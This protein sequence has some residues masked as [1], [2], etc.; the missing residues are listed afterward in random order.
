[1]K[2]YYITL[3]D[4]FGNALPGSSV[5]VI[6]DAS[7]QQSIYKDAGGTR[8]TNEAGTVINTA[9]ADDQGYVEFYWEPAAGHSLQIFSPTGLLKRIIENFAEIAVLETAL[10]SSTG[11]GMI[12]TANGDTVQEHIAIFGAATPHYH[13][14]I[15][16]NFA[17]DQTTAVQ[18]W[19]NHCD[20]NGIPPQTPRQI[21]AK[22]SATITYDPSGLVGN[23]VMPVIDMRNLT[24][25]SSATPGFVLGS[26]S[27]AIDGA[28]IYLPNVHRATVEWSGGLT[29]PCAA[30]VIRNVRFS[31]VWLPDVRYYT[32]GVQYIS[33]G[34]AIVYNEFYGGVL[35]DNRIGEQLLTIGASSYI[36]ENAWFGGAVGYSTVTGAQTAAFSAGTM[37]KI[38]ASGYTGN[39]NNVWYK[40]SYEVT[41]ATQHPNVTEG[42]PIWLEGANYNKW[43]DCRLEGWRGPAMHVEG[44]V[45][46][47]ANSTIGL[48]NEFNVGLVGTV[49]G[50]GA[51]LA[52]R[53]IKGA[54]ANH[55]TRRNQANAIAWDSGPLRAK[56]WSGGTAD[57]VAISAPFFWREG[58]SVTNRRR[59]TFSNRVATNVHGLQFNN[60]GVFVM[61]DT[62]RVKD[63]TFYAA[64]L[65]GWPGDWFFQP[66]DANFVKIADTITD[67]NGTERS[68]KAA[69][70]AAATLYGGGFTTG[71]LSERQFRLTVRNEV[72]FLVVGKVDGGGDQVLQSFGFIAHTTA[73]LTD[74]TGLLSEAPGAGIIDPLFDNETSP[75]A[76]ANPGSAGTHGLY[77]RGQIVQNASAASGQPMG[78]VCTTAGAL[79]VTRADA[80]AYPVKGQIVLAGSNAY[81]VHV[82]GTTGTGTAP[83]G[84]TAGTD[85]TD[86]SV[87]WRYVGPKAVF[88]ALANIA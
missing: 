77:A 62:T 76:T 15:D 4:T 1:M 5:S 28:H 46:G 64:V 39:N 44:D 88:A 68:V 59:L 35:R 21:R 6:D 37:S 27:G 32:I 63:F 61:I 66:L 43:H 3:T 25:K 56:M 69:G 13:G 11:A 55:L 74:G 36:N 17:T 73:Q 81:F 8:F 31:K 26:T 50:A 72:K 79:G 47:N 38:G 18:A 23:Q 2:K 71:S 67:A 9:Y 45:N 75:T 19:L 70:L 24:L 80:T 87:T 53:Q 41:E 65:D 48:D 20:A 82:P 57:S 49:G 86:G 10:A 40:R 14:V 85:Y 83:T 52:V 51:V 54:Y 58:T 16:D 22:V 33:E 12:G 84:T 29:S 30:V 34:Q 7:V 42:V 78:W 60:G